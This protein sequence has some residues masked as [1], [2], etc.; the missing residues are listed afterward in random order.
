MLVSGYDKVKDLTCFNPR[1]ASSFNGDSNRIPF[2][3]CRTWGS[4]EPQNEPS[5]TVSVDSDALSTP[6]SRVA[7][8]IING[9]VKGLC[10]AHV[11]DQQNDIHASSSG[12]GQLTVFGFVDADQGS[13]CSDGFSGWAFKVVSCFGSTFQS[14]FEW[15]CGWGKWH[16]EMGIVNGWTA[17]CHGNRL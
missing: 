14:E 15:R 9:H 6:C 4:C 16:Q 8:W 17:R 12:D 1:C 13:G 7:L 2:T 11:E 10:W 5:T 3:R